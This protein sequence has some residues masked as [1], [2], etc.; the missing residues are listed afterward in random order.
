[1]V[2]G[3]EIDGV[4]PEGSRDPNDEPLKLIEGRLLAPHSVVLGYGAP[5]T[6]H[7]HVYSY[8]RD[9]GAT[10]AWG[11][12]D[13]GIVRLLV[14]EIALNAFQHAGSPSIKLSST[15]SSICVSYQAERFG[16]HDLEGSDGRGGKAAVQAFRERA[17]GALA[18]SYRWRDGTSEWYI[19]D[20]VADG[21]A[22]NPCG[23]RLYDAKW[24]VFTQANADRLTGC[25]E[26]HIYPPE[27]FSFSDA[28]TLSD[29]SAMLPKRPLVIHGVDPVSGLAQYLRNR[30]PNAIL[31][32]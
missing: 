14:Y 31:V 26:V 32:Y 4:R 7:R 1:M 2:E 23:I 15:E 8:L 27:L 29:L 12:L 3:E 9:V 18:L 20:I 21:G 22:S 6:L 28:A 13:D 30:L 10:T 25:D 5:Q 24:R 19:S 16:V 17:R 11:N